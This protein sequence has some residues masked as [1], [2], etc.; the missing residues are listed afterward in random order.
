MQA[1]IEPREILD[2]ERMNEHMIDT[3]IQQCLV[4][5]H[6]YVL[7]VRT[8]V[9]KSYTLQRQC[10][11]GSGHACSWSTVLSDALKTI[12]SVHRYV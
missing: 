11:R 12:L 1:R 3:Y 8:H 7:N 10:S 4:W 5:T 9:R 2:K 6:D